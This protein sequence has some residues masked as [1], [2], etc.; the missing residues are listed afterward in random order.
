MISLNSRN[1]IQVWF[2]SNSFSSEVARPLTFFFVVIPA[3]KTLAAVTFVPFRLFIIVIFRERVINV[4]ILREG[5]ISRIVYLD[6]EAFI[7][8]HG[9]MS[10]WDVFGIED[11]IRQFEDKV[12]EFE[13]IKRNDL[14]ISHMVCVLIGDVVATRRLF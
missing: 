11:Q 13:F 5:K 3:H 1:V 10:N 4:F 14:L 7:I 6:F 12:S 8:D 2:V 9:P